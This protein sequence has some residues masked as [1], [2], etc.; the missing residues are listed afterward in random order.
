MKHIRHYVFYAIIALREFKISQ[1]A[2]LIAEDVGGV[3]AWMYGLSCNGKSN[4]RY[5]S[6][7]I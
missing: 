3:D 7:L 5:M 6:S 1:N 2:D 4:Q